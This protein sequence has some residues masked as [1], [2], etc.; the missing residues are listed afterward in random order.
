MEVSWIF[1]RT[2]H[3]WPF[4]KMRKWKKKWKK[5]KR[6]GP[7]PAWYRFTPC[8]P[9]L[10]LPPS[11]PFPPQ[12]VQKQAAS[13]R[14]ERIR[15]TSAASSQRVARLLSQA[16]IPPPRHL[17]DW[18]VVSASPCFVWCGNGDTTA[19]LQHHRQDTW[20][21]DHLCQ[22]RLGLSDVVTG[23]S[24]SLTDQ[25]CQHRLGSTDVI[26]W[27]SRSLTNQ[28]CQYRLGLSDVVTGT[29]T[30]VAILD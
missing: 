20:S 14:R 1:I 28:L 29:V 6:R 26:T 9:A 11:L 4:I 13:R 8:Y 16:P 7:L 27:P 30:T 21:T 19:R 17:I 24:R 2:V 15:S 25:L 23:P 5:K 22:Y 18:P 3:A 10:P 12:P